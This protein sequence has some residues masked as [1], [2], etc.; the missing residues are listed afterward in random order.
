MSI[1][2]IGPAKYDFQD[3]VCIKLALD[4]YQFELAS[5]I[6]EGKG[7]EDAEISVEID[8]TQIVYEIQV[9][10]SEEHFGLP[11]LAECLGHFPAYEAT[12]FFLE[13]LINDPNR[14]AVMVMSGRAN[15]SLQKF[16]PRGNWRGEEHSTVYFTLQDAEL[17]IDAMLS[18][19]ES[20]KG[21]NLQT[22]RKTYLT[23]YITGINKKSLIAAF[24]R[25][26]I[27]DGTKSADL[28]EACRQILR[29]DFLVPDDLFDAQIN[30]LQSVMK[31]G[32]AS[33]QNIMPEFIAKLQENPTE[34]VRPKE[35]ALRGDENNFLGIL[36]NQHVLLLSGKPRVGKSSVARWI[37]ASYQSQGYRVL[38]TQ[39]ADAAERFLLDP[40]SS[41]R[42]VLIDDPLGGAHATNKPHEKWMLLKRVIDN[43]AA[44]RKVIVAQG[45]DRLYELNG[46][47]DLS[48]LQL[49]GHHWNDL[50][51]TPDSFL[52]KC[53]AQHESHVP[54]EV[55]QTISAYIRQGR[56]NI[57]PGCLSYLAMAYPGLETLDSP[58]KI[59]RFAR[60]ESSDLGK[61]L[62]AEGYKHLLLGLAVSTSHLESISDRELAWVLNVES[63]GSYGLSKSSL[64][65]SFG[66]RK[67][68]QAMPFPEYTPEPELTYG[69]EDNLDRLEKR[70]ILQIDDSE[71]TNFTHPFYRSAA[72]SLFEDIGRREFKN[73][74]RA[75][76]KGIF[77]L[78]PA[79]ARASASNL[80]WIYDQANAVS[81]KDTIIQ[82]AIDGLDSSYPSVRDICFDFLIQHT[83]TL[84]LDLQNQV[85]SWT[86]KV[87][88]NSHTVL[89]WD[90]GQPWYP[91][92]SEHIISTRWFHEYDKQHVET[93]LN[94]IAS[95]FDVILTSKDAYDIVHH[96]ETSQERLDHKLMTKLLSVNERFIRALAAKLWM[97]VNRENDS[98]ILE[99]IFNETHPAVAE[100]V[101]QSAMLG[102]HLYS[103][104]RQ[105][106]VLSALE[107]I[108]YQPV[109][110]NAI[111]QLLVIF[112]REH[113]TGNAPP[114]QVFSRLFPIALS[115]LTATMHLSFARLA[116]VVEEA[117]QKLTP[118]EMMDVL[119][120]WVTFLEK[121]T[122]YR[123]SFALNAT[124][125]LLRIEI[126]ESLLSRRL[127]LIKRLLA[128]RSTSDRMRVIQDLIYIWPQLNSAE[129][130][131]IGEMLTKGSPDNRWILAAVLL[132]SNIPHEL[133]KYIIPSYEGSALSVEALVSL[134][135]ELFEAIVMVTT[136]F[137][138]SSL[139]HINV[140]LRQALIKTLVMD[141]LSPFSPMAFDYI[142][143]F[144]EEK[145][146]L[147]CEFINA[148]D[149]IRLQKIFDHLFY[150]YRDSNPD[151]MPLVWDT[152]FNRAAEDVICDIWL[153]QFVKYANSVFKNVDIAEMEKFIPQR[154]IHMFLQKLP[155]TFY[156]MYV[157]KF[158]ESESCENKG[159][160]II[161]S[162]SMLPVFI[163]NINN[164]MAKKP[165]VHHNTY[166]YIMNILRK[167]HVSETFIQDWD[168]ARSRLFEDVHH[169]R[170]F[171]IPAINDWQ[172]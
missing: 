153:P 143:T 131:A 163:K 59:I 90:K 152:L 38:R 99:R 171:L 12:Q 10:G 82:L 1:A 93:L 61:G 7:A 6:V 91:M 121:Q 36:Q 22:E 67:E 138:P 114:W 16:I 157:N 8:G 149:E 147:L 64:G 148:A 101:F 130:A 164:L 155:D 79:T 63:E 120:S 2:T 100:S 160:E 86:Y 135:P 84:S 123:D 111:I 142:L 146:E 150:F 37:A 25:L 158:L 80:F 102:W 9:K 109:L 58:E 110:A 39:D 11:L 21:S 122:I 98:D 50:S 49:V 129:R 76:R 77:C 172:Y 107:R 162:K 169:E 30:G 140:S 128:L 89:Q 81:N 92:N 88:N 62:V 29:K 151:Y 32:R 96:L 46:V 44:G 24:K 118:A 132:T 14:F 170:P 113:A 13:R 106:Y 136:D 134:E 85:P 43:A 45:Q 167:M 20:L 47:H 97:R 52:L 56:L 60:K 75:L 137:A 5:L 116:N 19:A 95:S 78:S 41:H 159:N 124:D 48:A 18:H 161:V 166:D 104:E 54:Y 108:A 40:V 4:F 51:D 103:V 57:E 15:D 117:Q 70:H 154:Y 69:D 165:P 156:F 35:Y 68:D 71:R 27:T 42:L 119:A 3:L 34:T 144:F 28:S 168:D 126:S 94:E 112:E 31:T 87:N 115:S 139:Y 83:P 55:Y 33:Q 133:V 53:W 73:I 26:I 141:V 125:A 72:E 74:E 127:S 145:E 66:S 23:D 65:Y 17:L 105:H